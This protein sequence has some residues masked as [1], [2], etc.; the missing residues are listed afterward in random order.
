V[1]GAEIHIEKD[2]LRFDVDVRPLVHAVQKKYRALP[3]PMDRHYGEDRA[4][5][6]RDMHESWCMR[7][8]RNV[9]M[10]TLNTSDARS[11]AQQ[12]EDRLSE[13]AD[14]LRADITKIDDPKAIALFEA[15]AEVLTG[16][17]RAFEHFQ[18]RSEPAWT[19]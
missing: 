9:A 12:V 5:L 15:A 19:K 14:H 11:H 2:D 7:H 3:R 8:A 16:L 4:Q 1:D 6:L 17:G 13:L 18:A 10:E